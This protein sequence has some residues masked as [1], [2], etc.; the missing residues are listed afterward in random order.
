MIVENNIKKIVFISSGG[1]VYGDQN[2]ESISE[3][4]STDPLSSY[5]IV[6]LAME[7]YIQLYSK[8]YGVNYS[9]FR[10]SNPYGPYQNTLKDQGIIGI[11]IRKF[12]ENG[13][14]TIWGDGNII[15]DYIYID[16]V[17]EILNRD[18][19]KNIDN[20]ILLNLGSGKG[21]SINEI[22]N[23]IE[24]ISNK[25]INILY[26]ESR[27]F[28]VKKN[29]LNIDKISNT[30]DWKPKHDIEEGIQNTYKWLK[31]NYKSN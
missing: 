16:D 22:L 5:G 31:N 28:D 11:F 18:L 23:L 19:M 20:N 29:I 14:I 13:E 8:L 2:L 25:K 15:R 9:I 6:K 1:T 30:F 27:S 12:I 24:R 21:S 7:K 3:Q 17:I 10:L 4:S 26:K